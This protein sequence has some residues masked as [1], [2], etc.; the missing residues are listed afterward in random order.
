MNENA[1]LSK[2]SIFKWE[3]ISLYQK[4]MQFN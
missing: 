4:P 1:L 3:I 2:V